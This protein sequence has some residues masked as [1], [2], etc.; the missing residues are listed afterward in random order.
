MKTNFKDIQHQLQ[1]LDKLYS[2]QGVVCFENDASVTK[3]LKNTFLRYKSYILMAEKWYLFHDL[4]SQIQNVAED[5]KEQVAL[6]F[7]ARVN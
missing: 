5:L 6:I 4:P 7:Y 3:D 1:I 2:L